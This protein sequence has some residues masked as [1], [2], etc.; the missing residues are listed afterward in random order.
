MRKFRTTETYIEDAKKVH[1]DQFDYSEVVFTTLSAKVKIKCNRCGNVF[2]Q[3]AHG[4]LKGYGCPHC[5]KC[6]YTSVKEV[7][8]KLFNVWGDALD[9]SE[10]NTFHV[11]EVVKV[12]CNVCGNDF[13]KV[14]RELLYGRGCK[15]QS[16]RRKR[17][18]LVEGVGV[19]DYN[20]NMHGDKRVYYAYKIWSAMLRRC[21]NDKV[22][23]KEPT[24][25]GCFV[26]DEWLHFSCFY[27]WFNAHYKEGFYI[28]KDLRV[29]GN[30]VYSPETCEFVPRRINNILGGRNINHYNTFGLPVGVTP[31]TGTNTFSA[32]LSINGKRTHIGVYGT[33]EE[34]FAAYKK[35]REEYIKDV[36]KEEY[37][38]GNIS[39]EVYQSLMNY[40]ITEGL[41]G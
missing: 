38:K 18:P 26:C 24:Y 40:K 30:K 35:V 36:A 27:E 7:K 12:H 11:T 6:E 4:H 28:D 21:Y 3:E 1:G 15:C 10:V 14:L 20:G 16:G 2:Y 9:F 8:E 33:P 32:A 31:T 19:N 22:K 13:E 5:K 34:A 29:I 39:N 41:H 37:D 25:E 17:K 23:S